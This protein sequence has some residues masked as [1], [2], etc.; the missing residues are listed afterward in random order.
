MC[1]RDSRECRILVDEVA[2]KSI[3]RQILL[4]RKSI[5]AIVPQ[6]S[7]YLAMALAIEKMEEVLAKEPFIGGNLPSEADREN[8]D[9]L[10]EVPDAK[11]PNARAW[12]LLVKAFSQ[13]VRMKWGE[14]KE[15]KKDK[16]KDKKDKKDKKE[17]KDKDKDKEKDKGKD[18]DKKDDDFNE[19]DLFGEG[20]DEDAQ[21]I[22]DEKKKK[23]AENK[24][25][26]KK[27]E[28]AKSYIRFEVKVYD[29]STNLDDLALR[30]FKDVSM[31]GLRWE[32]DY[33]L[34]PFAFG[35]NKLIIS[36]IVEDDKV[37]SDDIIDTITQFDNE[38]LVQSVDILVFSKL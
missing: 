31:E 22:L 24:K 17:K 37:S 20:G 32:K 25:K 1:I 15:G 29:T 33:N 14:K 9:S 7:L 28:A 19:D 3:N 4:V 35:V 36:C 11:F 6:Q 5:Y 8:F 30:I 27:K 10:K 13:E 21:K 12:F 23:D 34:E 2:D 16:K 18:K 26:E 38:E